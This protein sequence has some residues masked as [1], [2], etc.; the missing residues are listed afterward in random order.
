[1]LSHLNYKQNLADNPITDY[2][3]YKRIYSGEVTTLVIW[4]LE[5]IAAN[6]KILA[7]RI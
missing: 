5:N 3:Q 6:L 4:L 7:V 2:Q 1:M